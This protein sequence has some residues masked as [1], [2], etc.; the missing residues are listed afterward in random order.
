MF[1]FIGYVLIGYA[2]AVLFPLPILSRAILDGWARVGAY[3]S[4]NKT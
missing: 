3:L 1:S 2:I 4:A